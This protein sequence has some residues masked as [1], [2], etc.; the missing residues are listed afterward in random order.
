[1]LLS[2]VV[3]HPAF[4]EEELARYKGRAKATL[5]QQR[6]NPS[7]LAMERLEN[8]LYDGH[9]GARL[10]PTVSAIDG[11]TAETLREFHRTRYVPDHAVIGFAGDITMAEA[12][13]LVS[14]RFAA[15]KATRGARPTV[16]PV[17]AVD[18]RRAALVSRPGSVQTALF[19]GT[20]GPARASSDY[21][22]LTVANRVLGGTMGRLFRHL[23]EEKGY[24]YGI[25]S[26]INVA[27]YIGPWMVYTSVRNQVT[28]PALTDL[29]AEIEALRVTPVP[30]DELADAKRAVIGTFA[31]S[32]ES[33]QQVLSYYLESW[34]YD[35][36]TDYWTRYASRIAAVSAGD[37]RSSAQEYWSPAR[38][39]IVTVGDSTVIRE[40]LAKTGTV[41]MYD[42]EGRRSH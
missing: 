38:L 7:L 1:D 32:L 40:V 8:M 22:P 33:P 26:F 6:A 41:E 11:I 5:M 15:W 12:R 18:G 2:D 19:I 31:L 37:V 30:A 21:I 27:P 9:P 39:R 36:P 4:K 13:R 3:L 34:L 23:R 35:L 25:S 14:Q 16:T 17:Q 29:L 28:Q 24:T 10:I 20:P 42:V